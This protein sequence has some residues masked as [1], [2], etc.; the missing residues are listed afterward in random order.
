MQNTH[1]LTIDLRQVNEHSRTMTSNIP[2]PFKE[3]KMLTGN[4]NTF[5]FSFDMLKAYFQQPCTEA[6]SVSRP[7]YAHGGIPI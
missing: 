5:Y 7:F 6:R 3:A 2:L 4:G 1:K